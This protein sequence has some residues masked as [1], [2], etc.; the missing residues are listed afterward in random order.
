MISAWATLGITVVLGWAALLALAEGALAAEPRLATTAVPE[1]FAEHPERLRR[2]LAVARVVLLA[3]GALTLASAVR[4]WQR[5]LLEAAGWAL[6]LVV[7][8][9]AGADLLPRVIG[10]WQAGK[11]GRAAV[12]LTAATLD[13]ASPVLV[14]VAVVDDAFARLFGLAATPK[15]AGAVE[16]AQREMLFGVFALADTMVSEVMT[17]RVD[18][19]GLDVHCPLEEVVRRVAAAEHSRLPVFDGDLDHIVGVLYVK[20]LLGPRAAEVGGNWRELVRP[21]EIVPEVK[22]LDQQLRDFQRGPSH[23]AIVVD[24]FGGTAG[25]VTLEDVLEEIVGD[26]A[27]E[28]DV[29][30]APVVAETAPGVF[31]VDGRASLEEVSA[32]LGITLEHEEVTTAGGYIYAML[33]HVPQVGESVDVQGYRAV[34]ERVERLSIARV[35]FE[36]AAPEPAQPPR[37]DA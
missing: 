33:G 21:V 17:P 37:D 18:I 6:L 9:A 29:P 23:M 15:P 2:G 32:A 19:V 14:A 28:Y 16:R 35:R 30:S 12:R 27:D 10:L 26:I 25:I 22:T 24:E 8:V 5:P 31:V 13:M 7:A 34:V 36:R 20:D 11:V 3:L 1:R 4:W